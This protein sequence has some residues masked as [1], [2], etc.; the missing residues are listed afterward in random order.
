MMYNLTDR[1]KTILK[2]TSL[3]AARNILTMERLRK[4]A[5]N[6]IILVVL[7]HSLVN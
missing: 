6:T 3:L 4:E 5:Y 2:L 7:H 1:K